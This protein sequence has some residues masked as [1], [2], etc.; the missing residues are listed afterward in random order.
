M[1]EKRHAHVV[2]GTLS[3]GGARNLVVVIGLFTVGQTVRTRFVVGKSKPNE[4][5]QF[6]SVAKPTSLG[7]VIPRCAVERVLSC[8][9]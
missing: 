7:W 3:E 9:F 2:I 5:G 1:A 8:H 6:N 4:I